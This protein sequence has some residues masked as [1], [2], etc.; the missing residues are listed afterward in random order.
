M[1]F[2]L[3]LILMTI[4]RPEGILPEDRRRQELHEADEVFDDDEDDQ[5]AGAT[6][7]PA[8]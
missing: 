4:F 1:I 6:P 3:L 8:V 5:S 2:G 7:G